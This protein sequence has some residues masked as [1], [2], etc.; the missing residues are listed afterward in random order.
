MYS[1][2]TMG[3]CKECYRHIPARRFEE[4]GKIWIE[5]NCPEHGY[6]KNLVE[7]DA[8]FYHSL[9]WEGKDVYDSSGYGVDITQ[10]CNL[11]CPHC[12]QVP[13]NSIVDRSIE[14]IINEMLSSVPND[15]VTWALAGA[16]PTMRKDLPQL[17]K[18]MRDL[19]KDPT[20]LP[21]ELRLITNGVLLERPQLVTDLI[22][23]G[24]HFV[25]LSLH[26]PTYQGLFTNKRQRVGIK[27]CLEQGLTL[28]T[29]THTIG[30][31]DLLEDVLQV[32]QD[33]GHTALEY[34]VRG[35]ADIGR[36]DPLEPKKYL[37]EM[38]KEVT[39]ICNEKGWEFKIKRADNN[40][41]HVMADIN[42]IEHRFVQWADVDNLDLEQCN[43]GPWC[44]FPEIPHVSNMLHQW[45]LR[46][47]L[48]NKGLPKKDE[49]P[50]KYRR[51]YQ[52]EQEQNAKRD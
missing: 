15:G 25:T 5:K 28:G 42:D 37:S 34:R 51:M 47:G 33:F 4:D 32:N 11:T 14:A 1:V 13:D 29:I 30:H 7:P 35:G 6:T 46:D 23:A 17:I 18:A 16:E 44:K 27:N 8:E 49:I 26:H 9:V 40:V 39:R 3:L 48:V 38:I 41:Y 24:L 10:R 36:T 12:Y 45:I 22:E 2:D 50:L 21:R 31:L 52:W 43:H 20:Y 19:E